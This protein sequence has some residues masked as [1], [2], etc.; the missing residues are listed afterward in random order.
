MDHIA[1]MKTISAI[2]V[3]HSESKDDD[4]GMSNSSEDDGL[5]PLEINMNHLNM[6]NSDEESE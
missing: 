6:E 1:H 2:S 5:P 3:E 4:D